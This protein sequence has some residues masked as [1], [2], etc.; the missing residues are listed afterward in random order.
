MEFTK[1]DHCSHRDHELVL[2][3]GSDMLNYSLISDGIL[4]EDNLDLNPNIGILSFYTSDG[5]CF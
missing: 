4:L 5:P 2:D 1:D 3:F